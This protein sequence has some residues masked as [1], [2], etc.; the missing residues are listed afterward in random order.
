MNDTINE[1]KSLNFKSTLKKIGSALLKGL[2][3]F[4]EEFITYPLYIMSHP[5]KG[6]DDFKREKKGKLWA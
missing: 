4:K 3:V 5:I 1:S 2:K 6:F